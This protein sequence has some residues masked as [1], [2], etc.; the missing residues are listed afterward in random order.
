MD[1]RSLL[2]SSRETG[3]SEEK[4][5]PL[6]IGFYEGRRVIDVSLAEIDF[7]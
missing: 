4:V 5:T 7:L 1:E 2:T 6:K 3:A